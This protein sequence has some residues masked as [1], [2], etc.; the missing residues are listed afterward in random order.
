MGYLSYLCLSGPLGTRALV[1]AVTHTGHI[2]RN[3]DGNLVISCVNVMGTLHGTLT[4]CAIDG[5]D[6]TNISPAISGARLVRHVYAIVKGTSNFL[7][8]RKFQLRRL[9]STRSFRGVDLMRSTIGTVYRALRAGGAFRACTSRLTQL[10]HCTSHS[11]ISSTIH[12][13]GGTVLIVCRNLRRGQGRTSGASL[14]IRVGNV[15]GRCVRI[16]GP[17]RRTMPS[18]RFSVDG[19]SFS[20]L[21]QRFT[22]AQ[23]G[24]LLL[25]SLSRLIGRRLT[26]VLFTG[27]RHVSCCSHCRRVVST[28]GTRRG[29]TAVR[30]AFVSLVRLTDSLSARRRHCIHRNFSDSRRLSICSLLFS[31]GLA[32]RRVR[33]VGGISISLLAGVGRRVTGL[34]R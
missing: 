32:G 33:A 34:S 16:R 1:R 10:F 25:H 21:D 29:H 27:P 15:I 6:P 13:Q 17:S 5:G 24:G 30:G 14:V 8:R 7:T 11:S 18:Q 31:R 23:Q 22:R 12:T 2:S 9:I 4:S 3:G 28:C 19:V 26:G 20:L